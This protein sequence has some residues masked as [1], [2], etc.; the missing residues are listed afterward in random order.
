[1]LKAEHEPK[2]DLG[3]EKQY[4][5]AT[6][7]DEIDFYTMIRML[8]DSNGNVQFIGDSSNAS[9]VQLLRMIVETV[10]GPC[11]FALDPNRHKFNR[12]DTWNFSISKSTDVL[13][14]QETAIILTKAFFTNTY[15]V[16][17]LF[18]E[19]TFLE[20]LN[21]YY[22]EYSTKNSSWTAQFYMIL[23][24]G[25]C[26]ATPAAGS[27][28]AAVVDHLRLNFP[29]R[30]DEYFTA[31]KQIH[32]PFVDTDYTSFASVQTMTLLALYML[33]QAERNLA[34]VYTGMAVRLAY[35]QG[36]HRVEVIDALS[37]NER[38]ARQ[39]LWRS[40]FVLDCYQSVS[41]GRPL[42]IG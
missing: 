21:I 7:S 13:P 12:R 37:E 22:Q 32:N 9:F 19:K 33:F 31:A 2:Y 6:S 20:E 11:D 23:A 17:E 36:L 41:L 35:S 4:A 5:S 15:G 1:M 30:P 24:I 27:R 39:K 25:L 40:L 18:D 38:L 29:R 14:D 42:A 16:L 8:E 34:Y 28:E 26:L 3:Y 10:Y